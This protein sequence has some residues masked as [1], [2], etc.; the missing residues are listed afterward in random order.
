[1]GLAKLMTDFKKTGKLHADKEKVDLAAVDFASGNASEEEVAAAIK[2]YSDK[3]G[4]MLCPHTACGVV[5][6]EK[7]RD[8]LGLNNLDKHATVVLAT[9]HPGK[10]T[11]AVETACGKAP[12]LPPALLAAQ[13]AECCETLVQ[14]TEQKIREVIKQHVK[15]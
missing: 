15:I 8:R 6:A 12:I 2:A 5:A 3:H 14:N 11:A 13:T 1:M 10:Y 7:V 9:A 4:Y